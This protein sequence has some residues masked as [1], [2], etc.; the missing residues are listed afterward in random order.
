MKE[1]QIGKDSSNIIKGI[2]CLLIVA[3]HFCSRLD[4]SGYYNIFIHFIGVRGGVIGLTIFFFLSAWGLSESQK[5][6]RYPF[7]VFAKRRLSKIFIP[8]LLTSTIYYFILL[9]CGQISFN[10][11]SFILTVFN[12][13]IYDGVLWF[14]N[15][16]LIFYLFFYFAFLPNSNWIRI[17]IC[18]ITT[19]LYSIIATFL[20]PKAPF[21]VYSIV[22]FPLGMILSLYK[23]YALSLKFCV[24]WSFF[25]LFFLFS[26]V[27]IFPLYEK[28]FLMNIISFFVVLFLISTLVI[29][30][31]INLPNKLTILPFTGS[32]SYEIYLLHNKVLVL[33]AGAGYLVWYPLAFLIIVIPLA[34]LLQ[35]VTKKI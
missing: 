26:G 12:L 14:C 3:H 2:S 30:Q 20:F 31:K 6:N 27:F 7:M 25:F 8:L 22:G 33:V 35:V 19:T 16:I 24:F 21:Y 9:S 4:G 10:L 28:L 11:P 34:I 17:V 13:R 29:I 5:K 23:K 18:L 1:L 32:H 15:T